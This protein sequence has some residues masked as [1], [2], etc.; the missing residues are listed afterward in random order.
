[1]DKLT[2]ASE[3][4]IDEINAKLEETHMT[5]AQLAQMC[6]VSESTLTKVLNRSS[7]KPAFDTLAPAAHAI[8]ISTDE[9]LKKAIEHSIEKTDAATTVPAKMLVSQEDKF[10]NLFIDTHAKQVLD[11]KHQM[12]IKDRWIKSLAAV[13][14]VFACVLAFAALFAVTHPDIGITKTAASTLL[15]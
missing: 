1:M 5:R 11:L 6:D 7:K 15:S 12:Q 9:A 14:I 2:Y 8:G 3:I 10:L 4:L 13:I